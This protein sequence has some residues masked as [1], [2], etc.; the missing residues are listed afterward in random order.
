[1]FFPLLTE[2]SWKRR[3]GRFQVKTNPMFAQRFKDRTRSGHRWV[4]Q[5][6]QQIKLSMVSKL[7]DLMDAFL[8]A[9][10]W[11]FTCFEF[12][13]YGRPDKPFWALLT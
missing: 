13:Y 8:M 4:G 11:G 9:G 3:N 6:Q 1:M 12:L 5:Q 2:G 7:R 10:C